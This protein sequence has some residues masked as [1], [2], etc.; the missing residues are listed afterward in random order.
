MFL[1]LAHGHHL[2]GP[3]IVLSVIAMIGI[4]LL[5]GRVAGGSRNSRGRGGP[6]G[7]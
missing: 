4:R 5:A 3:E 6:W 1:L 2:T 7:R